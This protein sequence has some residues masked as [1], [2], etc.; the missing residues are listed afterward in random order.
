MKK[1][2][3]FCMSAAMLASCSSEEPAAPG[4]NGNTVTNP[5]EIVMGVSGLNVSTSVKGTKAAMD[6]FDG[7]EQ[8]TVFGLAKNTG[9]DWTNE[10][11]RLFTTGYAIGELNGRTGDGLKH[12]MHFVDEGG[13]EVHYYYPAYNGNNY[14]FFA[15]FPAVAAVPT[16]EQNS[17]TVNYT[18]D[19]KTD[20]M[21]ASASANP[22]ENDGV[23]GYNAPFFRREGAQLP[24]LTFNHMLSQLNFIF[25]KSNDFGTNE[26]L[27]VESIKIKNT[28]NSAVM[29]V[30]TF[31]P[32]GNALVSNFAGNGEQ[33][34]DMDVYDTADAPVADFIVL[35]QAPDLTNE[36]GYTMLVP[37]DQYEVEAVLYTKVDGK[38]LKRSTVSSPIKRNG[39]AG[40]FLAGTK[41]NV[42]FTIAGKIEIKIADVDVTPWEEEDVNGGEMGI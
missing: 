1:L 22:A 2:L 8:F 12:T 25:V 34:A 6:D 37:Q 40:P 18:I 21:L 16:I 32:E 36:V 11:N 29:T 14:S 10:A 35:D 39:D 19:G 42:T 17:V 24:S 41:Y 3:F 26:E 38:E 30:A 28:Y 7:T 15:C 31:N 13:D 4:N 9:T 23:D 5:D 20:I 27:I 33:N